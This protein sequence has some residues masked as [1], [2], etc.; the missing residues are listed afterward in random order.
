[1]Q[2]KQAGHVSSHRMASAHAAAANS[3]ALPPYVHA[4]QDKGVG[5]KEAAGSS[6]HGT[7][8]TDQTAAARLLLKGFAFLEDAEE[9]NAGKPYYQ[10]GGCSHCLNS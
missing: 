4:P 9:F 1:M 7:N 5:T 8:T 6:L 10:A 3:V 2:P